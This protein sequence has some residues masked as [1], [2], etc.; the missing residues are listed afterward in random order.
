[1]WR[2][3]PM[4][5]SELLGEPGADDP[6]PIPTDVD[7]AEIQVP[8]DGAGPLFHRIYSARIRDA[9]LSP[10]KLFER[11][12]SNLNA[13]APSEFARFEKVLGDEG[14]L[15][16]G[17][18]FV[19][20]MPGPWDG[21]VRVVDHTPCSFRLMTLDG[22]LEAGQIEFRAT[23]DEFLV[24]EIESWARSGDRLSDLLYDRLRMSK[25]IQLH[26]WTSV[27]ERVAKL[28]GGR[29]TGGIQIRT[30]RIGDPQGRGERPLGSARA[31][32]ALDQLHSRN[33]NFSPQD[34]GDLN[35]EDGWAADDY[36]QQLP[37]EPPGPPTPGGS[38]EIAS[39]LMRAYEFADP[40][41]VRAVYHPDRPL[42]GRDMLLEIRF[43][44]LRFHVGVR[45]GGVVD[46][47][48]SVE[49]R[50]VRIFGWSYRTLQGHLEMG[51]MDYELWKWLDTGEVQF[52]I[53]VVSKAARI[54]N[55]L[56]RLG[57][58]LFGRR[59]QTRFARRACERMAALTAG[60]IR[61]DEQPTLDRAA[62]EVAV[63][64]L[65]ESEIS[66]RLAVS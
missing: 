40:R 32:R 57:F 33:V 26:M 39:D 30:R 13:V 24:F 50:R 18:E 38:W 17:D 25:E 19:V 20:R 5:R 49:G 34:L 59:G 12:A 37:S 54:P 1:M 61:G 65:P 64:P 22:H 41:I 45:V 16:V 56:V 46:E 58:R 6:P 44:G 3:T 52:R 63:R 21:P 10:E 53:N 55:R 4:H 28:S 8:E 14:L 42:E 62:D 27:V 2:T 66:E 60:A 29:L 43:W 36:C 51:Q 31:R 15:E 7:N 48:R 9:E 23:S 47:E 35:S 11:L